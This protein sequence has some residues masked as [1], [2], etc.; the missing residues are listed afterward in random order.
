M[1]LINEGGALNMSL[2]IPFYLGY[3]PK[4]TILCCFTKQAC[5]QSPRRGLLRCIFACEVEPAVVTVSC[6]YLAVG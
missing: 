3:L 5:E 2:A 6:P 4:A 1:P